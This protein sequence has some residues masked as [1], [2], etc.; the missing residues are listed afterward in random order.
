MFH[1]MQ[2]TYWIILIVAII[3]VA[4]VLVYFYFKN[5]SPKPTPTTSVSLN[6]SPSPAASASLAASPTPSASQSQGVT[7]VKIFMIAVGDNG[8]S[9]KLIGCGDSAV[10]IEREVPQTQAVLKAAMEQLISI[11]DPTYGESGLT[12]PLYQSSLNFV[13]AAIDNG[14]ATVKFTGNLVL[15]GECGDARVQAQFEETTLQFPNVQSVDIFINDKNL[16]DLMSQ[17]G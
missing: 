8:A 7:K 11:K 14:K 17:T 13:S 1:R 3:L 16:R 5:K 9:G 4:V 2:K 6:L 15:P 10:A 12:N